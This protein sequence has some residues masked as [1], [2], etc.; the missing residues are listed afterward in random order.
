M[1]VGA[2]FTEEDLR[3][4]VLRLAH[5]IR[6]PLATIKSA[7]Q[8]IEHLQPPRA[9]VCEFHASIHLEIDRIDKVVR[10][11]QRFV[12]LD[13]NTAV[14]RNV[15]TIVA[16]A[17]EAGTPRAVSSSVR[18]VVEPGPE[19]SVLGD[20]A[21]LEA[22]LFELIDNAVRVSPPD[23]QV[24]VDW[25]LGEDRDVVLQVTDSGP[26]V[27]P[28]HVDRIFRPFFSTSTHG[29]GLGLNIAQRTA[30]IA[31]GSLKWQNLESVGARFSMILPRV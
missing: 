2:D 15:S 31:G 8:L 22:A 17:V 16:H 30:Q 6:N 18:I 12:R 29:T 4:M 7:V 25:H 3:E 20:A 28:K 14:S 21:Q 5:E 11:M 24:K 9:D 27:D 10:D 26:G 13:L 23:A 19:A 1:I